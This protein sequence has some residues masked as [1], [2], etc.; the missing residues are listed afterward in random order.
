MV[1]VFAWLLASLKARLKVFGVSLRAL[2]R[3]GAFLRS[4][5]LFLREESA[6]VFALNARDRP[7][8]GGDFFG[9]LETRW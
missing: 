2:A 6:P 3:T 5:S 4:N 1:T 9:D 7:E 8:R